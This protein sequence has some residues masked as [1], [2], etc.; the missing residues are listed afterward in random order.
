[1]KAK[2]VGWTGVLDTSPGVQF[3][4]GG[5]G[6]CK[7]ICGFDIPVLNAEEDAAHVVF[8][9]VFSA[10]NNNKVKVCQGRNFTASTSHS[11]FLLFQ[12]HWAPNYSC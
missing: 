5:P 11:P 3:L 4:E 2:H 12:V 10:G 9:R 6:R 1:M 7:F 8:E